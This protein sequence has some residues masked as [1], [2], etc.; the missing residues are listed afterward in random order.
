MACRSIS[1]CVSLAANDTKPQFQKAWTRRKF[2]ISQDGKH[3]E[4]Q[5]FLR[6]LRD[7]LS[8]KAGGK[9]PPVVLD[10]NAPRKQ[11]VRLFCVSFFFGNEQTSRKKLRKRHSFTPHCP[12]LDHILFPIRIPGV[13]DG[14]TTNEVHESSHITDAIRSMW[15]LSLQQASG[16]DQRK[17]W[18]WMYFR[19]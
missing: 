17:K 5:C 16:Q 15:P 18:T 3:G 1:T 8:P 2:I 9:M 14:G 4:I 19:S 12:D 6:T 11:K 7:L 13:W 10:S